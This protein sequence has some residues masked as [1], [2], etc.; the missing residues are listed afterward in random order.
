[1]ADTT[2]SV[3]NVYIAQFNDETESCFWR[4]EEDYDRLGN[5][6]NICLPKKGDYIVTINFQSKYICGIG[7]VGEWETGI[8]CRP[9][10]AGIERGEDLLDIERYGGEMRRYSNYEL[11]LEEPL[12]R[13]RIPLDIVQMILGITSTKECNNFMKGSNTPYCRVFYGES[14]KE[15]SEDEEQN[16]LVKNHREIVERFKMFIVTLYEV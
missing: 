13:V 10:P 3:P 4:H 2:R 1:M 5:S 16:I 7:V 15:L 6:R 8:P 9:N 14:N 11:K 12:R